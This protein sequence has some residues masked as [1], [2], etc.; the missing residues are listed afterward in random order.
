MVPIDRWLV[1]PVLPAPWF[2]GLMVVSTTVV[3]VALLLLV[4]RWLQQQREGLGRV[5]WIA[6]GLGLALSLGLQ[7]L[8]NRPRPEVFSALLPAPALPSFPSGHAVAVTTLW[9]M[10]AFVR[11][12]FAAVLTTP[13][14]LVLL[15][16]VALGHHHVSDVVGGVLLGAGLGVAAAGIGSTP[17]DDPWRLRWLLWPQIGLVACITL[18]AYTGAFSGGR[19]LWASIPNADKVLHFLLFGM[20]AF[21]AHFATRGRSL[22]FRGIKVPWAVLLPLSAALVEE[23]MQAASPHRTADP[24]DLLADLLGLLSFAWLARRLSNKREA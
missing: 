7:F 14:V 2:E 13:V 8:S 5:A 1:H 23:L 9:A 24:I 22:S 21:G 20:V 17:R 3:F 12:R 18:V 19:A 15:S 16:R 6:L 10:V 4:P 11:P